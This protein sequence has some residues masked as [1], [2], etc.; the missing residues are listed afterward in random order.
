M[1]DARVHE[2]G[3]SWTRLPADLHDLELVSQASQ[4]DWAAVMTV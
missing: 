2:Q 3:G 4:G 1:D